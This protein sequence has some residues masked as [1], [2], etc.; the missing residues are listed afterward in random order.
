VDAE[1]QSPAQRGGGASDSASTPANINLR[2]SN[3][4][5][6][7]RLNTDVSESGSSSSQKVPDERYVFLGECYVHG[8]MAGEAYKHREDTNTNYQEFWLV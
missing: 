8:M 6:D 7:V 4:R 2:A 3:S 5:P 1:I